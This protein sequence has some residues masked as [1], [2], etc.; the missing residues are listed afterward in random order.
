MTLVL[1]WFRRGRLLRSRGNWMNPSGPSSPPSCPCDLAPLA[2]VPFR[3]ERGRWIP[4]FA[5]KT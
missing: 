4:A 1:R 5:G 3:L 2:R